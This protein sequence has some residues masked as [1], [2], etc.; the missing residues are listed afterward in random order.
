MPDNRRHPPK[1]KR[2][3][4]AP[5]PAAAEPGRSPSGANTA[6][7]LVDLAPLLAIAGAAQGT[8]HFGV[9]CVSLP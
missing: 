1:R 6:I 8:F 9:A 5:L 7:H 4:A 3:T 2:T